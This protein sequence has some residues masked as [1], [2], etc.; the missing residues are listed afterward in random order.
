MCGVR[1]EAT[2]GEE[3]AGE[4]EV[5]RRCAEGKVG[6]AHPSDQVRSLFISHSHFWCPDC[7]R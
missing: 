2:E 6:G 4:L 5:S 3:E 7:R 1:W